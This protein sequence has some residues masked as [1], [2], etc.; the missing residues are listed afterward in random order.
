MMAAHVLLGAGRMGGGAPHKH[1]RP[2][3]LADC[4]LTLHPQPCRPTLTQLRVSEGWT[5]A[6]I[7]GHMGMVVHH[8]CMH[9]CA[10]HA[11]MCCM[12]CACLQALEALQLLC[13]RLQVHRVPIERAVWTAVV[14]RALDSHVRAA[15]RRGW[16]W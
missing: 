12:C 10:A 3:P 8:P 14:W 13:K 1:P 2:Q 9:A 11:S 15:Q 4:Q 5:A 6:R 16:V 7:G